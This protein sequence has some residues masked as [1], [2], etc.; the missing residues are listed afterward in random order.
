[1]RIYKMI[2]TNPIRGFKNNSIC[3][4]KIAVL[5]CNF[6]DKLTR[7]RNPEQLLEVSIFS[8]SLKP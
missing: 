7:K 4:Q 5:N 2:L 6:A 1:M 8:W 3:D